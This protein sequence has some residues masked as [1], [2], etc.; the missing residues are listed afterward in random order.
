MLLLVTS[1]P[2]PLSAGQG[3]HPCPM[4][5]LIQLHMFGVVPSTALTLYGAFP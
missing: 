4:Q 5:P 3:G 2:E 1:L